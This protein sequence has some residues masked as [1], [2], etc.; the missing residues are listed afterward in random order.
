VGERRAA[1]DDTPDGSPGDAAAE[2][3]AAALAEVEQLVAGGTPRGEAARRVSA[4]TGIPRRRLYA[5][6]DR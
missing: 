1:P 3:V 2:G 5:A 6:P 4:V